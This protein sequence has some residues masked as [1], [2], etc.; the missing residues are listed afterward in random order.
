MSSNSELPDLVT[1]RELV[2]RVSAL[3]GGAALVGQSALLAGC[4][5]GGGQAAAPREGAASA[6]G[7]ALSRE[8][9]ALLDEVADT[10]LPPTST[11]GAKAAGVGP[12][13]A[14]MVRDTYDATEQRIFSDGLDTLDALAVEMHGHDFLSSGTTERLALVERLD[15]EQF[16]YTNA[17]GPDDPPHYFRMLKE[18]TLLGYF[19]SEIGCTQAQR[20][21]ETPGRFE[22][23]LPYAPGEK[24]WAAHA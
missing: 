24:S 13:I 14:V 4:A 16:D 7:A 15:R 23:C 5:T 19:T 8:R 10:I 22:A 17:R 9:I 20:Y 1:R 21:V 12:F 3:L 6:T 2:L 18:L 11:P